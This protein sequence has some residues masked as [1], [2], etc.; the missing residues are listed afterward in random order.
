MKTDSVPFLN[1]AMCQAPVKYDKSE[2]TIQWP[3]VLRKG[4]AGPH[5]PAGG[6][7]LHTRKKD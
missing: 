7:D 5:Q 4:H 3:C 1:P 2:S 6:K